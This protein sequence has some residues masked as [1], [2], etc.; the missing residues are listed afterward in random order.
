MRTP[1]TSTGTNPLDGT[2]NDV[3][4][5]MS[6]DSDGSSEADSFPSP[7]SPNAPHSKLN[8]G[9]NLGSGSVIDPPSIVGA[10]AVQR[11]HFGSFYLRMGAVG[12][13]SL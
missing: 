13:E 3:T 4:D 8:G 1:T 7:N 12:K 5:P 11:I 9:E 6:C 10:Y 2:T